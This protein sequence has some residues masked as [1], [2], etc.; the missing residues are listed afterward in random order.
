MTAPVRI[1]RRRIKGW[2]MPEGAIYVGRPGRFGNPFT[3]TRTPGGGWSV[4]S[5]YGRAASSGETEQRAR[6]H[7]VHLYE[8]YV[9]RRTSPQFRAELAALAGH[10]LACWC[11]LDVACHADVLLK[12]ANEGRS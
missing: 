11:R 2:T 12:L 7:A 1:Q 3:V 4:L 10:D 6:E 8:A 5:E 9:R